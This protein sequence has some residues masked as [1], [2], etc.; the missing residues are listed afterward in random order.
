MHIILAWLTVARG[1]VVAQDQGRCVMQQCPPHHFPR[2]DAGPIY[3]ASEEDLKRQRPV[4]GIEKEASE[5]LADFMSQHRFQIAPHRC[6]AV[7]RGFTLNRSCK[8]PAPDLQQRLQLA[9]PHRAQPKLADESLT[10]GLQQLAQTPELHEQ[11]SRQLHDIAPTH[12]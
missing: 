10:V 1:V 6:R 3:R 2:V 12:T 5:H 9:V 8:V 4:L 7:H 11:T